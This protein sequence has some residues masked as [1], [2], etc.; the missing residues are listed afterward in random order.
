MRTF[1]CGILVLF[2]L[3]GIRCLAMD[4][5][6][7]QSEQR[8]SLIKEFQAEE[9]EVFKKAVVKAVNKTSAKRLLKIISKLKNEIDEETAAEKRKRLGEAYR[10][11]WEEAIIVWKVTTDPDAKKLIL[12]TWKSSLVESASVPYQIG[13]LHYQWDRGLLTDEFWSLLKDSNSVNTVSSICFAIYLRGNDDDIARLEAKE[14]ATSNIQ[15]KQVILNAL[16]WRK[17]KLNGSPDP[18]D[19]GPASAP[20]KI[21]PE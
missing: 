11:A 1:F 16:D 10:A 6:P 7:G 18:K 14:T 13:A 19:Q 4:E 17:F 3:S 12:D 15:I 9:F 5:A 8:T 2:L 21:N 20:P